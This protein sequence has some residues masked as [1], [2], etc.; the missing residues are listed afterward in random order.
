MSGGRIYKLISR[1]V[2]CS[3]LSAVTLAIILISACTPPLGDS[4]ADLALE[5]IAAGYADSRLKAQTPVP[6]RQSV[7]Y[8]ANGRRYQGDLYRS[9]E[10]VHAGIV[11]VPGVVP[12]GKN[13]PRLVALAYTLARLRFA[14]LV[15]DLVGLRRLKVRRSDVREVADAFAYL[16]SRPE[17]GPGGRAGIAGFSYGA[18]PVLLAGLESDIREQVRFIL[19]LGGYYD[20]HSIVS[21]FTTGYYRDEDTG[22]WRYLAPRSYAAWVFG[23]SNADLLE[24]PQ[25]RSRLRTYLDELAEAES[26]DEPLPPKGLAPDAEALLAL[27]GNRDPTRVPALIARLSPSMRAELEGL[28]PAAHDLTTLQGE[29]ILLHGRSDNVIPYTESV[30]LARSLRPGQVELFLIE[31]FAHVDVHLK[32]RDIP[33]LLG[34]IQRLLDHRE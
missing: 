32:S 3:G 7:R 26:G 31:G 28:N 21:Y 27:L 4:E 17:L 24:R 11:L 5:D 23:L 2:R 12:A 10:A 1:S 34:V 22:D 14:V 18:G 30:A 13:D 29:V 19:A 8:R 15:P 25:D 16:L 9:P 20:L 6:L 33:Q